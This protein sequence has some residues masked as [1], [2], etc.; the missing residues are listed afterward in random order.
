[1]LNVS[2]FIAEQYSAAHMYHNLF[3]HL[4]VDGHV[5]CLHVLAI[6]NSASVGIEVHESFSIMDFQGVCPVVGLLGHM[7]VLFLV[8]KGI[9]ILLSIVMVSIFIPTNS[10]R[11]FRFLHTLSSIYYL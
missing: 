10:A 5:G 9:S 8:F 3:I 2:L 6:V 4:P 7:T 1:M 11:G